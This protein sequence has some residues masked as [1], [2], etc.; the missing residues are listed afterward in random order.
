M[1]LFSLLRGATV[2]HITP[3]DQIK[4]TLDSY[5]W[6]VKQFG[7]QIYVIF[8]LPGAVVCGVWVY[9]APDGIMLTGDM[10][11]DFE[12]RASHPRM[13]LVIKDSATFD[14]ISNDGLRLKI[15]R[16]CGSLEDNMAKLRQVGL[17][18]PTIADRVAKEVGTFVQ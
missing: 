11:W 3:V 18:A 5:G 1:G 9:I 13:S 10:D 15:L 4:Q 12:R 17:A 6:N 7:N 16:I 8:I 14:E 2:A